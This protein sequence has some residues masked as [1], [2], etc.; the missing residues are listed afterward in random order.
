MFEGRGPLAILLLVLVGGLALNLTPC[1]LPMI[2]INLAIIGAGAQARVARPRLPARL[3]LRR[4]RWRSS[5]ACSAWS[6]SSRPAPSARSTRR[7]GSTSASRCCS[8]CSALAMFDVITDRLLAATRAASRRRARRGSV[9]AGVQHGRAS[10][11]CSPA[12]ASRRSSSRSCCS[13]AISTRPARRVALALPFFLG[14]GMAI[15]WPIAGA[16]IAALPKAGHVD[17]ARQAGRSASSSSRPPR[18]TATRRTRIFANRWVDPAAVTSSVAG[19]A[20]GG[21]ARVARRRPR[22]R[23]AREQAGADRHVGDLVQELPDDGQDDARE[24]SR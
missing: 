7:R 11:R 5:T 20:E 9:R 16:G 12:P 23:A 2:P 14:L 3:V 6:S 24:R 17:G 18:T 15:P 8:S 21:L 10:R 19:T 13:R 4:A 1:V 22:R